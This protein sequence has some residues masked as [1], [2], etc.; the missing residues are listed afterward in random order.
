M[1]GCC[2]NRLLDRGIKKRKDAKVE[3][4]EKELM[5]RAS[6]KETGKITG[7]VRI[8]F[9]EKGIVVARQYLERPSVLACYAGRQAA[10]EVMD[11]DAANRPTAELLKELT[12]FKDKLQKK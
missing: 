3:K 12:T 6:S 11:Q 7:M 1:S 8:M 9:G 5:K 4:L 10:V 2:N